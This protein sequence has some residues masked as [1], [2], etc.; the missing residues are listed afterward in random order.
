MGWFGGSNSD[1]A[2]VA[3]RILFYGVPQNELVIMIRVSTEKCT[4]LQPSSSSEGVSRCYT[5]RMYALEVIL[6]LGRMYYDAEHSAT[7]PVPKCQGFCCRMKCKLC[8]Q[9][10]QIS[11]LERAIEN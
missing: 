3:L 1:V 10:N 9:G 7:S 6:R 5:S 8:L 2:D 11:S 4:N